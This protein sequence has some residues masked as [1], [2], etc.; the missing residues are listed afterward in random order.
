MVMSFTLNS[1]SETETLA[2]CFAS[3]LHQGDVVG[4]TGSLGVGKSAFARAAILSQCDNVDDVPS[5]T[6]TL[7]QQ[8]DARSG[9]AL[10]HMDLYRLQ[11][12]EEVFALGVEDAFIDAACL[13]EWPER[14]G[15]FWPNDAI[16]ITLDRGED[17]SRH[18]TI[19]AGDDFINRLTNLVKENAPHLL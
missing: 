2:G 13:V 5:P 3:C 12:P 15:G 11:D 10:W 18:I 4:L 19:T 14:M 1:L 9:L 6:F 8:Y 16:M 7:V 17:D